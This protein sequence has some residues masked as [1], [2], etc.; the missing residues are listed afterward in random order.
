MPFARLARKTG[1]SSG[2]GRRITVLP[3]VAP[4]GAAD[5]RSRTMVRNHRRGVAARQRTASGGYF[6]RIEGWAHNK[7]EAMARELWQGGPVACRVG[8]G[9]TVS[10]RQSR[11][12]ELDN[13][14]F[15]V[16]AIA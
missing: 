5:L 8:V 14:V 16:H 10:G 9:T 2:E 6:I 13:E 15:V 4:C 11:S 7:L 12:E 3:L 1:P